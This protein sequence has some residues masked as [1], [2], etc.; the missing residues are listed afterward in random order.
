MELRKV[1]I[2]VNL[3]LGFTLGGLGLRWM[4][5]GNILVGLIILAFGFSNFLRGL[6]SVLLEREFKKMFKKIV[7]KHN[8]RG[9][10][11]KS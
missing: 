9:K 3:F 5:D 10:R 11:G 2:I 1:F 6:S 8:G 4:V 7:E